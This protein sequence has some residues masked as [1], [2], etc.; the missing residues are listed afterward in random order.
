MLSSKSREESRR[1]KNDE[2]SN[3]MSHEYDSVCTGDDISLSSSAQPGRERR[4][5][6]SPPREMES[7]YSEIKRDLITRSRSPRSRSTTPTDNSLVSGIRG[8]V[9]SYGAVAGDTERYSSIR[10]EREGRGGQ[11][12]G[13][14]SSQPRLSSTDGSGSGPS[15]RT[16]V[17]TNI[18]QVSPPPNLVRT[19]TVCHLPYVCEYLDTWLHRVPV[20]LSSHSVFV[21][22]CVNPSLMGSVIV[23]PQSLKHC[24][25][26]IYVPTT[27]S[28]LSA[29]PS[30]SKYLCE[31][32]R[33]RTGPIEPQAEYEVNP[34]I[35]SYPEVSTNT[36]SL[37]SHR[38]QCMT[39][40][41]REPTSSP[42]SSRPRNNIGPRPRRP[43]TS[44]LSSL[45]TDTARFHDSQS[46]E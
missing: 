41:L 37:C 44:T 34:T 19:K 16:R 29:A 23:P 17:T 22:W 3:L 39:D 28:T 27:V 20:A 40:W 42:G 36:S 4:R 45:T 6:R 14:V 18:L 15:I 24:Q 8:G 2:K 26:G 21:C 35:H 25:S 13:S 38:A 30:I 32:Q 9:A 7:E 31:L 46:C 10:V 43:L 12:P 11:T 1:V 33:Q 5:A